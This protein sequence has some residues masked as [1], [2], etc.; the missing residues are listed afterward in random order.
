[1]IQ[2]KAT[3]YFEKKFWVGSF[4]RIDQTGY[5]VAKHIFGGE[6]TDPEVYQFVLENYQSLNFGPP[7]AFELEIKR[8][9]PK[10][11]QREVRKEMER[12][13]Q[14]TRPSTFAEDYMRE[15][16]ERNKRVKKA[17]TKAQKEELIEKQFNLKQQKR[18]EKRKG[19]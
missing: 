17:K 2:I 9:N 10:R 19:H 15:E 4:E 1:M 5:A 7:K 14:E 6:P 12:V 11:V 16:L 8:K 13:K 3:I 18:K